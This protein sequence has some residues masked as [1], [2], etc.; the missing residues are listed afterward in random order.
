MKHLYFVNPVPGAWSM[1]SHILEQGAEKHGNH[2][3][4]KRPVEYYIDKAI[5]HGNRHQP[6]IVDSESGLPHLAHQIAN[7]MI[8]LQKEIEA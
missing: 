5:S 8:Q 7:L 3:Y 1:V 4:R 2:A 6:D